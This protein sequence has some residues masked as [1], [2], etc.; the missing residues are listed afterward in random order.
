MLPWPWTRRKRGSRSAIWRRV[1]SSSG[2]EPLSTT[3]NSSTSGSASTWGM[4][5]N[6]AG[7]VRN[8][9]MITDTSGGS[10]GSW[11][12]TMLAPIGRPSLLIL[13]GR[14]RQ[15]GGAGGAFEVGRQ[16]FVGQAGG[17]VFQ[18][19]DPLAVRAEEAQGHLAGLGLLAAD[20]GD[21]RGLGHGMLADLVVDLLVAQVGLHA[22]AR[23]LQPGGHGAGIVV[24]VGRDGGHHNLNGS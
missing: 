5:L 22:K 18:R 13:F 12:R 4:A 21:H 9:T 11:V 14:L 7:P 23:G 3:M 17:G 15:G 1:I 6:S 8:T 19:Q 20:D 24:S 2:E 16:G 10:L